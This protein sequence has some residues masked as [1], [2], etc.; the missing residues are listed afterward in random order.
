M[1]QLC[2]QRLAR[3][4]LS[5]EHT[6]A[7]LLCSCAL[8]SCVDDSQLRRAAE[9]PSART[10]LV[11]PSL[12]I[13]GIS[14]GAG[15]PSFADL[16]EMSAHGVRFLRIDFG[17]SWMEP[18]EGQY[19][20]TDARR[21][22]IRSMDHLL[23]E[24][25]KRGIQILGMIGYAPSWANGDS[26]DKVR[27]NSA[28]DYA[29]FARAVVERYK[30][31]G[32]GPAASQGVRYWELWNEP[33]IHF[34]VVRQG[35]SKA[36]KYAELVKAAY[37]AIVAADPNAVVL[38]G[39][40]APYGSVGEHDGTSGNVNPVTF[41]ELLY[42][43]GVK[44]N[45]DGFSH[46]PYV[47]PDPPRTA[48]AWHAWPQIAGTPK[49]LRSVMNANG[50]SDIPIWGTEVGWPQPA[51]GE[52]AHDVDPNSKKVSAATAAQYMRDGYDYWQSATDPRGTLF[53]FCWSDAAFADFGIFRDLGDPKVP[54]R[55]AWL[56]IDR[57]ADAGI[58]DASSPPIRCGSC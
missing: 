10:R 58:K 18:S 19:N 37:P 13:K 54:L 2:M 45:F 30:P 8:L 29:K 22:R 24:C 52:S 46:H 57:S 12:P 21:D 56:S 50:D 6:A 1:V 4:P 9:I 25:H 53:W 35:E 41:L 23:E 48:Q 51:S 42:G 38:I 16:D 26:N 7:V 27:P 32:S 3:Q 11:D 49:S 43:H 31:G 15:F 14:W 55:D 5:V 44:G 39:A 17:W 47:Y 36:Q 40:T 34:L 33:N 28:D 20:F